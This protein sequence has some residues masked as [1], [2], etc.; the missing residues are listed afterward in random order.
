DRSQVAYRTVPRENPE[1]RDLVAAGAEGAS[2]SSPDHQRTENCP[3]PRELLEEFLAYDGG[4]RPR[5]M[6][7][8]SSAGE[9]CSAAA[10]LTITLSVGLFSPRSSTLR[11]R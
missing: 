1:I 4:H 5:E 10:S 6:G 9:R 3:D 11:Y 8:S 7:S 2:R